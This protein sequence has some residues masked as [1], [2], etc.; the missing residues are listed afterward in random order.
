M[1]NTVCFPKCVGGVVDGSC[2][3]GTGG[4][5][6]LFFEEMAAFFFNANKKKGQG[7]GSVGEGCRYQLY[8]MQHCG[9]ERSFFFFGCSF[10]G[11]YSAK[12]RRIRQ[13]IIL[14]R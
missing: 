4:A 7:Q 6:N 1:L 14:G 9:M 12:R 2:S 5:F 13:S 8:G 3:I 11:N 10:L